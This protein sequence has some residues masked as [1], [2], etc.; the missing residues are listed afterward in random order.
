MKTLRPEEGKASSKPLKYFKVR[1]SPGTELDAW[2]TNVNK[3]K[4]LPLRDLDL[5]IGLTG[6]H[7]G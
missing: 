2:D 5:T 6:R 7:V 1:V 4:S 3:T